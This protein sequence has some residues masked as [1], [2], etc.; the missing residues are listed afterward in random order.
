MKNFQILSLGLFI[1][2]TT[3][4]CGCEDSALKTSVQSSKNIRKNTTDN[5][6]QENEKILEEEMRLEEE[7]EKL[8]DLDI[9]P[10]F[11]NLENQSENLL[12]EENSLEETLESLESL[13]F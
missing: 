3:A 11:D 2:T 10:T 13:D 6:E 5:I 8:E 1:L 4:L 12:K 9:D 7:L